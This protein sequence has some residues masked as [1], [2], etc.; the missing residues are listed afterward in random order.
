MSKVLKIASALILAAVLLVVG[1]A[2]PGLAAPDETAP[3]EDTPRP[4][5]LRGV[6]ASVDDENQEFFTIKD[7]DITVF[8]NEDT[9]YFKLT[10]PRR[11]LALRRPRMAPMQLEGQEEVGLGIRP[12]VPMKLKARDQANRP[13]NGRAFRS[14]K[15][16]QA[17][18]RGLALNLSPA[19]WGKGNPKRLQGI[20]K[21]LRR[22]GE[23]AT[24]DDIDDGD[25]VV[26]R[27]VPRNGEPLAK[28]VFIIETTAYKRVKGTVSDI[29]EDE[30][31]IT[32]EP[33][34]DTEDGSI[35]LTYDGHTTFVLRG[36]PSLK[37]DMRAV[38][39]YV[40]T[41][42]GLLAKRVMAGMPLPEE[43]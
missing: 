18:N 19:G 28:Q 40:E 17:E 2:L 32:I 30:M 39:I 25:R 3:Q 4:R 34:S 11:L 29:N 37:E 16:V 36:T 8:V 21:W 13:T 1:V 6:V 7:G 33:A 27:V 42:D 10:V 26:V 23:E 35:I 15:P 22:F 9:K 12:A 38:A 14:S 31:T 41:D 5:M 20:L 24:F 43:D